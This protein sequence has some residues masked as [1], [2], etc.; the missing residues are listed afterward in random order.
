MTFSSGVGNSATANLPKQLRRLL[1]RTDRGIELLYSTAINS[2]VIEGLPSTGLV[3][4]KS[5][6]RQRSYR[7]N[8]QF[9]K[10]RDD[11]SLMPRCYASGKDPSSTFLNS[12]IAYPTSPSPS[13]SNSAFS[14]LETASDEESVHSENRN[15]R[16]KER[17]HRPSSD[18]VR[19]GKISHNS[20]GTGK[21]NYGAKNTR[22]HTDHGAPTHR[23]ACNYSQN[24]T[25]Y[26][27]E[28]ES[29]HV[30]RQNRRTRLR[31]PNHFPSDRQR[32][33]LLEGPRRGQPTRHP[34][35]S[36]LSPL[37]CEN[38]SQ[39]SPRRDRRAGCERSGADLP[40]RRASRRG[41]SSAASNSS[42]E[43]CAFPS[44]EGSIG[45]RSHF[46]RRWGDAYQSLFGDLERENERERE[47][48]LE[49]E[50][51]I[52]LER[53]RE[54][55]LERE[56][57]VKLERERE[58]KLE[59]ER[60]LKLE[61][62]R[63]LKQ[64]REHEREVKLKQERERHLENERRREL[65]RERERR[66]E[67]ERELELKR[68]R[69]LESERERERELEQERGRRVE[70]ALAAAEAAERLAASH[71]SR[72]GLLQSALDLERRRLAE[73][74]RDLE[75]GRGRIAEQE[76]ALEELRGAVARLEREQETLKGGLA[77]AEERCARYTAELGALQIKEREWGERDGAWGRQLKGLEDRLQEQEEAA[78]TT[79][80]QLEVEFAATAGSYQELLS[81]ATERM[82][83][84]EKTH[85]K[86]KT[87]K[88]EHQKLKTAKEEAIGENEKRLRD[89]VSE[90]MALKGENKALREQLQLIEEDM[91]GLSQTHKESVE[92][93]KRQSELQKAS[94]SD[95]T[96]LLQNQMETAHHTIQLLRTQIENL[97][98]EVSEEQGH[99]QE[100]AMRMAEKEMKL[101]QERQEQQKSASAYKVNSEETIAALKRQ[102]REKDSQLR[103]LAVSQSEPLQRLRV[104]LEDERGKRAQLESQFVQYKR[105]AKEA[106][107]IALREIRREKLR[108][109][110]QSPSCSQSAMA[111]SSATATPPR[112]SINETPQTQKQSRWNKGT[113]SSVSPKIS[114]K[115]NHYHRHYVRSVERSTTPSSDFLRQKR[116]QQ[117]GVLDKSH[118]GG[119]PTKGL[120]LV[121]SP[122][123]E[124]EDGTSPPKV[125]VTRIDSA[126]EMKTNL[127][128]AKFEMQAFCRRDDKHTVSSSPEQGK[129]EVVSDKA[130]YTDEH[131]AIKQNIS[132]LPPPSDAL[133][134]A[135]RSP[136][137]DSISCISNTSP[138]NST[139]Q[140]DHPVNPCLLEMLQQGEVEEKKEEKEEEINMKCLLS[141]SS[142]K[143][144]V[145]SGTQAGWPIFSSKYQEG[146]D[147]Q[148]GGL[149]KNASEEKPY[150][151][152]VSIEA[153][154]RV[155]ERNNPV[156]TS[157]TDHEQRMR[158]FHASAA[159]IFKKITSSRE[160]FLAQCT[161][162]VRQS[163]A[164][165]RASHNGGGGSA[166]ENGV[167]RE[168][169]TMMGS[170]ELTKV[171]P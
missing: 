139:S 131:Q 114:K 24:D 21:G 119:K 35:T 44:G 74:S 148:Q 42:D 147:F 155:K 115:Q 45:M 85:R 52:K 113:F 144:D 4:A 86:Y 49:R 143:N 133:A 22:T 83:Y 13:P 27:P 156:D 58:I 125:Q 12:R 127:P 37:K 167:K 7:T 57:G 68:E 95:Q 118:G 70:E 2:A 103:A 117:A 32:V 78:R 33:D 107:E 96:K 122:L 8:P 47:L 23:L 129:V 169:F 163:T 138:C 164:T 157:V 18:A 54:L 100:I 171:T 60:E 101:Q 19:H 11:S 146:P 69:E 92:E 166:V 3:H 39:Q 135:V 31:T 145:Y 17:V 28:E 43:T 80:H 98:R 97:Q 141:L 53:E 130:S 93:M 159:E 77:S 137:T 10:R 104:Q 46:G 170:P 50:R 30:S 106:E 73:A 84:L 16:G 116:G 120:P 67:S 158:E 81:E 15:R 62:E 140:L 82:G 63:E 123:R 75:R 153:D 59:R 48:K 126:G 41:E 25:G 71:A 76:A 149:L 26:Y 9:D 5:S 88:E 51:E 14:D 40:R 94:A 136:L 154:M 90:K 6:S 152:I 38:T 20:R 124:V 134:G 110:G 128:P 1:E 79:L 87:L 165:R 121:L 162:I 56:R 89:M 91:K 29:L 105:K 168:S 55:K 151:N 34:S 160:D 66:L 65:E 111:I 64:E 142:I 99:S 161:S 61:R 112:H 72:Q 102:L 150:E 108:S 132:F 109:S 36:G